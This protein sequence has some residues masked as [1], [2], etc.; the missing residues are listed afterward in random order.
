MVVQYAASILAN[1]ECGSLFSGQDP[2]IVLTAM[3]GTFG[4]DG[5]LEGAVFPLETSP[6]F[7]LLRL[8]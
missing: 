8:K 4:R 1:P 2:S 7:E 3:M 5:Q 6:E